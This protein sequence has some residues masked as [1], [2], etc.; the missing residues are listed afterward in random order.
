MASLAAFVQ[1]DRGRFYSAVCDKY[2]IDPAA[3]MRDD[4][5]AFN[6]RAGLLL[7]G[8]REDEERPVVMERGDH[9]TRV[10][11]LDPLAELQ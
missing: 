4:V 11:G 8:L 6:L 9:G 2:G 3:G 1:S 10:S 5:V 7:A